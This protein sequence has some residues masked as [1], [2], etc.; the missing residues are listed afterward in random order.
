VSFRNVLA[1]ENFL[2]LMFVVFSIQFV[3][4]S[5]GPVLP[6]FIEQRGIPAAR[7]P[8]LAGTLFSLVA[9]A[10][11]LGHHFLRAPAQAVFR[12]ASSSARERPRGAREPS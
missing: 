6:L 8:V 3:D 9:I 10:G 1:F 7:V 5:F 11:A 2:L 4:R 12:P